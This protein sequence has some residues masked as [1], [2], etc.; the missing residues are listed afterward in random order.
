MKFGS[1]LFD[2]EPHLRGLA[3]QVLIMIGIVCAYVVVAIW[4]LPL[5]RYQINPD[6]ISYLSIAR[7]YAAGNWHE[8]INGYW[9]PLYSWM[10]APVTYVTKSGLVATKIVNLAIGLATVIGSWLL[11]QRYMRNMFLRLAAT[12]TL[13]LMVISW[14]MLVITPDLLLVA[15]LV[16]YLYVLTDP[17]YLRR[18]SKWI[19]AGALGALAYFTKAYAFDFFLAQFTVVHAWGAYQAKNRRIDWVR[20]WVVGMATFMILVIPWII[21]ISHKYH[22]LTISTATSYNW[23][24]VGPAVRGIHPMESQGLYPLPYATA[25]SAWDDP[26]YIAMPSW[27]VS[28]NLKYFGQLV[29]DN[30]RQE[31]SYLQAFSALAWAILLIALLIPSMRPKPAREHKYVNE[32]TLAS[33]LIFALGYSLV[34]VESR[35]IWIVACLTLFLGYLAIDLAEQHKLISRTWILS[36]GVIVALTFAVPQLRALAQDSHDGE[37]DQTVAAAITHKIPHINGARLASSANWDSS[38]Y[39]SFLTGER[40]IGEVQPSSASQQLT[41]YHVKYF[42]NWHDNGGAPN[43]LGNYSHVVLRLPQYDL[44]IYELN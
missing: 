32:L 25:V 21:L 39:L 24:L 35:Y 8:A 22:K 38:L 29:E 44:A 28:G 18:P 27:S 11:S 19:W 37:L 13:M 23:N 30:L 43:Y 20:A 10:L 14:A 6:G 33:I 34:L 3:L 7:H 12:V 36:L 4:L 26:S 42:L 31:A 2:R 15:I 1:G 5:H 9:S 41:A 40:Y 16:W 17:A